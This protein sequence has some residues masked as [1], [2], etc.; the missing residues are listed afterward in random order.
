MIT[1]ANGTYGTEASPY[2]STPKEY[3]VGGI[4][5]NRQRGSD[6]VTIRQTA[7][8]VVR[9]DNSFDA[10]PSLQITPIQVGTYLTIV[11]GVVTYVGSSPSTTSTT[12]APTSST[13]TSS[14]T[15]TTYTTPPPT[16]TTPPPTT[17]T[18]YTT[19]PPTTTTTPPPTTTTTSTTSPPT[20]T[21]PP[22]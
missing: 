18:T 7:K 10:T 3:G 20:T 22:P 12:V 15:T 16:T 5:A 1:T 4:L 8:P 6:Q 2:Q 13:T 21:T 11:G 19:P 14:T 9:F 17:T